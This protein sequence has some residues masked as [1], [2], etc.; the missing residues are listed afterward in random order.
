[1]VEEGVRRLR[2]HSRLL[3]WET[4]RRCMEQ[5]ARKL[6]RSGYPPTVRHQV[7]ESALRRWRRRCREEDEGVRP[8]HRPME[9]R[10]DER[11]LSKHTKGV[12]WHKGDSKVSAP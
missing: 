11:M 9:W 12:A 1:M 4:S 3:E 2:N 5:F 8:V 7:V 10:R 6:K